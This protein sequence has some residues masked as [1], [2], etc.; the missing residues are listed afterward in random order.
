ME[1]LSETWSMIFDVAKEYP[2]ILNISHFDF[3]AF[4]KAYNLTVTRCFGYSLPQ[5]MIVPLA[6]CVNHHNVDGQ[7]ELFHSKLH[8]VN[9]EEQF[10]KLTEAEKCYFTNSR[11]RINFNRAIKAG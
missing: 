6:D 1:D 3:D 7:Y 5:T 10:E 9:S 8:S 4:Y 2:D 11:R